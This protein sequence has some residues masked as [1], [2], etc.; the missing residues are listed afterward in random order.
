MMY[1]Q[2]CSSMNCT[3][4]FLL[5]IGSTVCLM[6]VY[7]CTM[8][9]VSNLIPGFP[10]SLLLY[11]KI[12]RGWE[13]KSCATSSVCT[14][15]L[16]G[17]CSIYVE[18]RIKVTWFPRLSNF[19]YVVMKRLGNLGTRLC[20]EWSY[21]VCVQ[22]KYFCL[23]KSWNEVMVELIAYWNF[24]SDQFFGMSDH[25]KSLSLHL[26]CYCK[27]FTTQFQKCRLMHYLACHKNSAQNIKSMVSQIIR[28]IIATFQHY[29]HKCKYAWQSSY[30][31]FTRCHLTRLQLWYILCIKVCLDIPGCH[32]MHALIQ[33]KRSSA[34]YLEDNAT[35]TR[36]MLLSWTV[37]FDA[38]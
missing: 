20:N 6:F 11:A 25:L 4:C 23:I 5:L 36:R 35:H 8:Y 24:I 13:I 38:L 29:Q 22:P 7:T 15:L 14:C 34:K 19:S 18:W 10:A 33:G 21:S 31:C 27:H 1:W 37:N 26:K 2:A 9:V 28:S 16:S 17:A 3:K 12:R 32:S 30:R